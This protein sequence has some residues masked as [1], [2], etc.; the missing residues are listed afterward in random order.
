MILEIAVVFYPHIFFLIKIR[1][2]DYIF[3][4]KID[5][6][7]FTPFYK[8]CFIVCCLQNLFVLL[9]ILLS[10]YC[11]CI[12]LPYFMLRGRRIG[13][14]HFGCRLL[15]VCT[16]VHKVKLVFK[17]SV[18]MHTLGDLMT[19]IWRQCWPPCDIDLVP[20]TPRW[21][22]KG[23]GSS[24]IQIFCINV[25]LVYIDGRNVLKLKRTRTYK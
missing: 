21:S 10:V 17:F 6:C 12:L 11:I 15:L 13:A 18:G 14:G 3:M 9:Y 16:S 2:K 4:Y 8:W 19:F 25:L 5:I 1:L 24:H 20:V 23:L 7:A 22:G